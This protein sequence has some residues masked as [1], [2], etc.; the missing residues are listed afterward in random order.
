MGEAYIYLYFRFRCDEYS[1]RGV[2][3][4]RV[5]TS[6]KSCRADESSVLLCAT[7]S[8]TVFKCV[9]ELEWRTKKG[10]YC[11]DFS[12]YIKGLLRFYSMS[13]IIFAGMCVIY[14]QTSQGITTIEGVKR[15]LVLK[16][17]S[18]IYFSVFLYF[19]MYFL[20]P[21][22][23]CGMVDG[24]IL[25]GI[26]KSYYGLLKDSTLGRWC[27]VVVQG[28]RRVAGVL[29]YL[30]GSLLR[31]DASITRFRCERAKTLVIRRLLYCFF[32]CLF[33]RCDQSYKGVVRSTRYFSCPPRRGCRRY[34]HLPMPSKVH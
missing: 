22:S 21:L 3:Y 13:Y 19:L 9:G 24:L 18:L 15:D 26:R 6:G 14:V 7:V 31:V 34:L 29:L 5:F 10:V 1:F 2:I 8:S 27:L 28:L 11:R 30:I 12:F 17:D 23:Y 33:Q 16:E 25:R 20:Y 4:S 32:R